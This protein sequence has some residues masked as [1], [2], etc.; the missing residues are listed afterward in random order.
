[1]ALQ[2]EILSTEA[3]DFLKQIYFLK[4]FIS[5]SVNAKP[6]SFSSDEVS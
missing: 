3:S 6:T 2:A 1:M 4:S 5:V